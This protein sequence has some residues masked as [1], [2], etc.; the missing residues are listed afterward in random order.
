MPG[1]TANPPIISPWPGGPDEMP[2]AGLIDR[3]APMDSHADAA[4]AWTEPLWT[5]L[6]EAGAARWSIPTEFGGD[7]IDRVRLLG[8][9]AALAEASLTAVFVLTQHDA[10]ARHLAAAARSGHAP[11]ADYLKAVAAGERFPTVGISQLTTS[12]RMGPQAVRATASGDGSYRFDG[13]MPWVT[14]ATRA[15]RFVTGGVLD[16][17]RKILIMLDR[18]RPG[19]TVPEPFALAALQ[20]SCTCEVR[21][22]G[23]TIGPDA[24]LV[25]PADEVLTTPGAAG[26]GGLETSALALGQARAA[27]VAL[28]GEA[29]R[30]DDLEESIGALDDTWLATARDLLATAGGAPDAPTSADVRARANAIVLRATQAYLTAR[31]GTGFLRSEPAQR[32]ARQALFFLVWSC[33]TPVAQSALRD[34]AGVCPL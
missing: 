17:G 21:L 26:T 33:P 32:W 14:A 7:G 2:D 34:L 1:T 20:A 18:D 15:D 22:D 5:A 6:R 12:R 19:V 9:Y 13:V 25:G 30:R 3:L 23:V 4:G 16:D 24:I 29:A 10:A 31:K 8:R 11:A 28:A 27:L